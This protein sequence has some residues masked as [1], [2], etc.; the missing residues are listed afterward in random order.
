MTNV[1]ENI[2]QLNI[3]DG[4]SPLLLDT[5]AQPPT[6]SYQKDLKTF[7]KR[8]RAKYLSQALI[9]KLID[10]DSPL[11]QAYWRTWHCT[12][13]LLQDGKKI[14][15]KYCNNR[16]C[17]V[18]NRIRTAKLIKGYMPAVKD[19]RDPQFITLTVPNV[20]GPELKKTIAGM[21]RE[22]ILIKNVFVRRRGLRI[23][24]IRKLEVTYNNKAGDYH[25]HLHI[26]AE[27]RQV[28][29]ALIEEWL[30]RHP[31]ADRRGQNIRPADE[32]S[33]IE[34][35]KYTTKLTTKSLITKENGKIV[36]K[37]NPEALDVI[38]QAMYKRRIFQAMGAVR[39][40]SEDV[41]EIDSQ[42]VKD[43]KESVDVWTWQQELS[44]WVNSAGELLTGCEA[45]KKYEVR[46]DSG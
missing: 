43:L 2:I 21:I 22:F 1:Q 45:Y 38:F 46:F 35:F 19:L 9:L 39:S 32:S 42:V 20:P 6:N 17:P 3:P 11:K 23:N 26:V 24:G 29:E 4:N 16:W 18:C 36:I 41:E 31:E 13:V 7:E 33:L 25:P 8:A 10:L 14:T 12:E 40:V 27:G 37:V 28:G 44:D 15:A 5:L 34:L 30:Q